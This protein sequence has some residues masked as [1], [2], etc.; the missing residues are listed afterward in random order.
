MV[1]SKCLIILS[2]KSSGSTALQNLLTKFGDIKCVCKTRHFEN[3]TLYWTKAASIL[4]L[5][6][7]KMLDSEVPIHRRKAKRDLITVLQDNL[8]DYSPP[9]DDN[10]LIFDGWQRMC[11]RYAP[12]FLEKSPH[13]LG[14]WSSLELIVQCIESTP[15]TDFLLI[16]LVRNPMD[17]I[18]SQFRRWRIRPEKLQYQWLVAYRNLSR[19]RDIVGERLVVIRYE[20]MVSSLSHLRTILDFCEVS[21]DNADHTYLHQASLLKWKRDKFFGFVLD[22]VVMQLAQDYGYQVEDLTNTSTPIWSAYREYMR[23]VYRCTNPLRQ[24]FLA[25]RRPG[26]VTR[27]RC[28]LWD[29]R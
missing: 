8:D 26:A 18:Y 7:S 17:T 29:A 4:G 5:S 19:L 2:E 11:A 22:D 13:H 12:I 15:G 25:A 16:G 23:A 10:E 3:E 24:A 9:A 20:D 6:Q 14:Q 1:N 28:L 27:A 21:V